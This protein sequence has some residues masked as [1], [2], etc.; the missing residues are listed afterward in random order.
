VRGVLTD[1]EQGEIWDF[2]RDDLED[3]HEHRGQAAP[4]SRLDFYEGLSSKA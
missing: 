3:R 1:T 2:E 4:F